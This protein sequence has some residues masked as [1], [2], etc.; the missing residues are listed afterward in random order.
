MTWR[1][2]A[3]SIG[4]LR[5][6]RLSQHA[7]QRPFEIGL[8]GVAVLGIPRM[9]SDITTGQPILVLVGL[10]LL[11]TSQLIL[12]I[13]CLRP[14]RLTWTLTIIAALG[15][16]IVIV[17]QLTSHGGGPLLWRIDAW[18]GVTFAFLAIIHPRE[19]QLPVLVATTLACFTIVVMTG[20]VDWRPQL[21]AMV[22]TAVPLALLA[23]ARLCV[24]AMI[25]E[26]IATRNA[27]ELHAQLDGI[28]RDRVEATASLRRKTHDSLLHCLQLIGASW[29]P[30]TPREMRTMCARTLHQLSDASPEAEG[31]LDLPMHQVLRSAVSDEACR[32]SWDVD[33]G[34]IA[35]HV[36][37]TVAGAAR[38]AVRNVVRHCATPEARVWART[39]TEGTRVE[40]SDDGPGF[41]V[42]SSPRGRWGLDNSIV[43]RMASIG[44]AAFVD[45]GPSGTTISLVWPAPA[46]VHT[47]TMGNRARIWLSWTPVPLVVGSVANVSAAHSGLGPTATALVWTALASLIL[48]AA[49]RVRARGLTDLQAWSMC[50]IALTAVAANDAWIDPLTTDGWDLWVPSLAGCLVILALPGRQVGVALSMA[51]LVLGGSVL[52]SLVILGQHAT[53]VTHYGALMAVATLVLMTLVLAVGAAGVAGYVHR[54]QQLEAALQRRSRMVAEREEMWRNWLHLARDLTGD[55]LGTVASGHTDPTEPGARRE[56]S[57]L[58]A[59]V[60]DELQLWPGDAEMAGVLDRMR[61][62]GWQCWLRL[63]T[64]DP[65]IRQGVVDIL[66]RLPAFT[67]GQS[68]LVSERDGIATITFS[69]PALNDEQHA[70]IEPWIVLDD[71]DFTQAR[72]LDASQVGTLCDSTPPLTPCSVPGAPTNAHGPAS[73]MT[74]AAPRR[75]V[76]SR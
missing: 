67:P 42:R 53:W 50:A 63:D 71:R 1:G 33:A 66:Q 74:V 46:G 44:G 55:F 20:D 37:V 62:E 69:N 16:V 75:V 19:R 23:L 60:R 26:G 14:S 38:E 64:P 6:P 17:G 9:S 43:A 3:R 12:I 39:S 28:T 34:T 45:S 24:V 7:F 58:D 48:V 49:L 30:L 8:A 13:Q 56:A 10:V 72:T 54:T 25:D 51:F 52:A 27:L 76:R 4:R 65:G 32:L 15:I 40:I 36:S 31:P 21:L 68:L 73:V 35:P 59:R 57:W 61:R 29:S 18:L 70:A 22:F 47:G 41:D 5:L 2:T 11:V